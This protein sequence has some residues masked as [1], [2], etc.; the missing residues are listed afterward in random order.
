MTFSLN[1]LTVRNMALHQ[2]R[3]LGL[4]RRQDIEKASIYAAS[5]V[6]LNYSY[7]IRAPDPK[8][9]ELYETRRQ[10][11]HICMN[12]MKVRR[13]KYP[14]RFGKSYRWRSWLLFSVVWH[15][16]KTE[17]RSPSIILTGRV[18]ICRFSLSCRKSRGEVN[19]FWQGRSERRKNC[20]NAIAG[21]V[22]NHLIAFDV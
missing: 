11:T 1:L 4:L 5:R 8:A 15:V 19:Q 9:Q 12:C 2:C 22:C 17:N 16:I 7:S 10:Q 6:C 3:N 14:C 13:K 21:V 20:K 18:I